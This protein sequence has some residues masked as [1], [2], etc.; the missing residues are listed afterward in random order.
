MDKVQNKPN[1]SVDHF[2]SL[3]DIVRM[4]ISRNMRFKGHLARMGTIKNAFN[5][6]ITRTLKEQPTSKTKTLVG[7]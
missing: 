1:S 4:I 7:G 2:Y 6:L 5:V 3:P